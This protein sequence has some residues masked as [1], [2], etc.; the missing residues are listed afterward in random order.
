MVLATQF[1]PVFGVFYHVVYQL[2]RLQLWDFP[3][4]FVPVR[5]FLP[6]CTKMYRPGCPWIATWIPGRVWS[7]RP[8]G[9]AKC[10]RPQ[11]VTFR[12]PVFT[13]WISSFD[14]L[15]PTYLQD[16]TPLLT[17]QTAVLQGHCLWLC[18][19]AVCEDKDLLA[20]A[21]LSQGRQ[22]SEE[23]RIGTS[24]LVLQPRQLLCA[25]LNS[26]LTVSDGQAKRHQSLGWERLAN[27]AI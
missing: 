20:F 10:V 22:A 8:G 27:A 12:T 25:V 3:F 21:S 7:D 5:W 26:V 24:G 19:D 11:L 14:A 23:G 6:L 1:R 15:D 4:F 18:K 16:A 9:E 17:P 13:Y 2:G